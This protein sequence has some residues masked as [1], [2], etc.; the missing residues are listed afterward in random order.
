MTI[1][2]NV[3]DILRFHFSDHPNVTTHDL[4]RVAAEIGDMVHAEI[5]TAVETAVTVRIDGIPQ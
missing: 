3:E 1:K 4:H 2:R 5:M